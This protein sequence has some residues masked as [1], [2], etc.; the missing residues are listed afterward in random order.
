MHHL[1][2]T[3]ETPYSCVNVDPGGMGALCIVQLAPCQC[4]MRNC[5]SSFPTAMQSVGD[6]HETDWRALNETD[7]SGGVGV[8]SQRLPR[9][10]SASVTER[11]EVRMSLPTAAQNVCITHDTPLRSLVSVWAGAGIGC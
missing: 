7:V 3:H 10:T 1:L 2:V 4:S 8:I 9:R 5:L 11:F 6:E